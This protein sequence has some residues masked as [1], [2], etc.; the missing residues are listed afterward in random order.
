VRGVTSD[1]SDWALQ[2][3]SV[4][5]ENRG[6]PDVLGMRGRAQQAAWLMEA[7]PP[8]ELAVLGGDLNTWVRGPNE[9][10]KRRI[11]AH[12]PAT[13]PALPAGPTHRSHLVVRTHID[14]LFARLPRGRMTDY[15]RV[16]AMYGSDH[17]PLLAWVHVPRHR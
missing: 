3:V 5:L 11:R 1:G 13:P 17:F 9:A 14:F 12:Y 10:A 15:E 7:L 4:H 6:G 2:V 8:A 16:P